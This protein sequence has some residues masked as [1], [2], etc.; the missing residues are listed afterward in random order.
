MKNIGFLKN[1]I[2]KYYWG[3]RTFIPKLMGASIPAGEPCAEL[4]LGSHPKA[5]SLV[6]VNG[7]WVPIT[8][9]IKEDPIAVLGESTASKF[10][11]QLPFLFKILAA[12]EPLSIQAHPNREQAAAGFRLENTLGISSNSPQ[13]NYRDANHKPELLCALTPFWALKGFR[14]ARE[15]EELLDSL[16]FFEIVEIVLKERLL[17]RDI[18]SLFTLLL[19]ADRKRQAILVKEVVKAV[20]KKGRGRPALSWIIALSRSF[21][22]D[23]GALAPLMLNL[24][25]LQ[26]GEAIFVPAGEL[27]AYLKGAAIEIM[28]NSDNVL[29][30][31]LTSKHVDVQKLL[32]IVQFNESRQQPIKRI[33][34][35][36]GEGI[37]PASADEFVLSTIDMEEGTSF[38]SLGKRNVEIL[39][40]VEGEARITDLG[41]LD[42][43]HLR[44]GASVLVPAAVSKY[45]ITGNGR[46]YKAAV[47]QE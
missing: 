42:T 14:E 3:S 36:G 44:Q 47:P 7:K 26:P 31:G 43:L 45:R 10:E 18:R 1:K 20:E 21:P 33:Q 22:G 46:I 30:G 32:E 13:R 35:D 24:I 15:R 8:D 29:R 17:N 6:D 37:Y 5:P 38:N 40:L 41:S 23:I 34:A 11:N 27:H 25:H 2:M 12:Q 4:W 39:I 28:A 19:C 16:A 9:I